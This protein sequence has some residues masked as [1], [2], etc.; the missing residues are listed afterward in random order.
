MAGLVSAPMTHR[1]NMGFCLIQTPDPGLASLSSE[2]HVVV[3]ETDR[4]QME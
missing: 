4:S 2:D 1:D 3:D